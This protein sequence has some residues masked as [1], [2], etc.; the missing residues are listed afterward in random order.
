MTQTT[1]LPAAVIHTMDP[2][3]PQAEAVAVRDGWTLALGTVDDLQAIDGAAV[4]NRYA[5]KVLLPGFVEA[6]SHGMAGALWQHT[7]CGFFGRTDPAGRAWSGCT[8]VDEVIDRL[9]AAD[10]AIAD[11]GEPLL[12]W[13][14]D[15]IYFPGDRL[16]AMHLDRVSTTRRIFVLHASAHLATVNTVLME[17]EGIGPDTLT[18]GV[19]KDAEG[20]P[21]GELQ[22]PAAMFLAGRTFRSFFGRLQADEGIRHLGDIASIAGVTT[23]TDLGTSAITAE[24]TISR[25]AGVVDDEAF[26]ARVS[27]FHNPRFAATGDMDE[28]AAEV[29]ALCPRSSDKLRLGHVKL[30]LDG[31]IQG[32]T[33]RLRHPGYLNDVP[34]GLWQIPPEQVAG[35][36]G[37]FHRAGLLVHAHCNGDEAV[38]VFLD[39]VEEVLAASPRL[40]HR[41]TV[42][43]SQLTTPGQYRRI[44]ALGLCANVFSNHTFFWGDQHVSTTV[45]ADRAARMNSARTALDIGVP[46]SIHTDA[47][48][49]PLGSLH[50][51]W[52]A[53]NRLTAGGRVLGPGER[54][55]VY[56]ALRAVTLGAAY[57]L[58]MDDEIGSLA[59]GKRADMVVL[60]AD[61]FD[62]DPVE[63]RD[64]PVAGTVLGGTHHP[65]G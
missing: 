30:V 42:Q 25:W 17:A 34:N 28:A 3:H 36:L 21:I 5:D 54:I 29:A 51:A 14:L 24:A 32:L 33:A 62:V 49:T 6:H 60:D 61:P 43:H 1:I 11:P 16:V 39:A 27:L 31:S 40:D 58:K 47:P 35:H 23:L 7:Y 44:A 2:N 22:E 52:C 26:P 9:R 12:A 19:L 64:V 15:P 50:A 13:G 41:H 10:A 59:P 65:G 4:D 20:W 56:E 46:L 18:E 63:L 45:G 8:S 37:A 38:D 55:S 53:V 57:Q 48:V